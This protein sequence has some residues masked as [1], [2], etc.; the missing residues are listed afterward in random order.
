MCTG[1]TLKLENGYHLFG[2]SLDIPY[3]FGQKII[4]VPKNMELRNAID[5][6]TFKT[7]YAIIG[8]GTVIENHP[9]FADGMN[10]MGLGCAGLNFG[11]LA[12]YEKEAQEGKTNIGSYDFITWILTNFKDVKEAK[13]GLKDL[14]LVEKNFSENVGTSPLHWIAY[15]KNGDCIVVE[16]VKGR[17]NVYDNP[18]GVLTNLPSFDWHLTNITQYIG[19]KSKEEVEEIKWGDLKMEAFSQGSGNFGIPGDYTSPSRFIR[20]AFLRDNIKNTANEVDGVGAFF[21]V[22]SSCDVPLGSVESKDGLLDK[23]VYTSCMCLETGNYYYHNYYNRQI[24]AISL[25]KEDLNSSTLKTYEYRNKQGF[26][27]EN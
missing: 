15:D 18:V 12:V 20:A 11:K 6:S 27:F 2:R 14:I 21:H 23:T 9:M 26:L 13:E 10:E 4:I 5:E 24:T 1:L 25:T 16:K 19:M 22:L 7:N 3:E 8:M 17:L